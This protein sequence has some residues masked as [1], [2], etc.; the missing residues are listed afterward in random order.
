[1][2]G[3]QTSVATQYGAAVAGDF[4]SKN[5]RA[6]FPAGPGGLVAGPVGVTVGLAA[7]LAGN[8]SDGDLAP[9][10]VNNYGAGSIAGIVPRSQQGMLTQ[11]LQTSSM[12]IPAGFAVE[13][14]SQGDMWVKNDGATP[15][16]IGDTAYANFK[17]GKFT[18]AA[19]NA[20]VVTG[21]I[22]ASTF[23][24]TAS[25]TDDVM[26]VTAVGSGTVVNGATVSGGTTATG[27]KVQEQLSGTAGGV[28]T[29]RV[30]IPQTVASGTLTGAYGTLTV[31]AV[32]SGLLGVG[33]VLSGTGVTAGTTVTQILTG[34]GG[35]GT[36]AVDTS[37]TATSTAITGTGNVAT[38]FKAAMPAAPGSLVKITTYP[39]GSYSY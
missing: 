12:L 20:G 34:T 39:V 21:S 25:I 7:W 4:A 18:F 27:T 13:V 14:M 8:Q 33:D 15:C 32:T 38:Q 3:F 30:N 23:S 37:Q 16:K 24:V 35:V 31:T 28:G 29:Y 1:M 17:D 6:F 9:A 5:P 19:A 2:S 11:Y 36:F 26:T 22:A 10:S